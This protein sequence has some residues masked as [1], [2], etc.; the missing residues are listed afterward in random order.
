M[1]PFTCSLVPGGEIVVK[2]PPVF[3]GGD[4]R[5]PQSAP[6]LVPPQST[7]GSFMF[8]PLEQR[9]WAK[10]IKTDGCW[11]WKGAT[12][13]GGRGQI[14]VN[15][16]MQKAPRI[17]YALCRGEVPAS[18]YVCHKCNNPLCVNPDHL[19]I[20]DRKSNIRDCININ[21]YANQKLTWE[22]VREIRAK[23][24]RGEYRKWANKYNVSKSLI[25]LVMA[26]KSWK[27]EVHDA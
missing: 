20:G 24:K 21:E 5:L 13:G 12:E 26:N 6:I 2:E 10:V 8:A 19:Y 3:W 14:W 9:F 17:A 11:I 25:H 18:A 27:E 7:G 15:G 16:R 1:I 23:C 22:Y 4:G